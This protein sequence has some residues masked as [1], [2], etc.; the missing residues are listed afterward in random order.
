ME[1]EQL[2]FGTQ[3]PNL[4]WHLDRI[5]QPH[6]LPRDYQYGPQNKGAGVDVYI[7]DTGINYDH[8][9]FQRRAKYGGYDPVDEYY[10]ESRE[11]RDCQGH[12]THVSSLVGGKTFGTARQVNLFSVRV[13][14]CTNFA[15]WSVVLDGL[16]FVAKVK[17]EKK[18]PM[19]VVMSLGGGFQAA[20]NEAIQNLHDMGV[21]VVVAAGNGRDD[22]CMYSPSSSE[23]AITVAGSNGTDSLY[24][25]TNFGKCIDIFAPGDRI[26]GANYSCINC[27]MHLSGTSMAT[28]MVA[29][30]AAMYLNEQPL[31]SP[32]E[33]KEK[34]MSESIKNELDFSQLILDVESDEASLAIEL[35]PNRLL[36]TK[37]T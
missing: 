13:L 29:G 3:D 27:T 16:D 8:L 7:L 15:P 10:G 11:G 2:A 4:P 26:L 34:L 5:D 23:Y 19:V 12:G 9:E 28:P 1:E 25:I 24:S 18:R 33:V 30:V 35:T 14:D 22:A 17:K 31:L 20:A 6:V 32:S 21:V 37:G 36:Q